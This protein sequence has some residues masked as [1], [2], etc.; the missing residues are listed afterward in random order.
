MLL[1]MLFPVLL[2]GQEQANNPA[3]I[4]GNEAAATKPQAT[5]ANNFLLTPEGIKASA[6]AEE[7]SKL[8]AAEQQPELSSADQEAGKVVQVVEPDKNVQSAKNKAKDRSL[9]RRSAKRGKRERGR[10]A[11]RKSPAQS[12]ETTKSG[13]VFDIAPIVVNSDTERL[14]DALAD[15][16]ATEIESITVLQESSKEQSKEQ[17]KPDIQ[18]E[19]I[20]QKIVLMPQIDELETPEQLVDSAPLVSGDRLLFTLRCSNQGATTADSLVITYPVPPSVVYSQDS[21]AGEA[22]TVLY[23]VDGGSSFAQLEYLQVEKK[24]R[25]RTP[26]SGDIT[27]VRWIHNVAFETGQGSVLTFEGFFK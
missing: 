17:L 24:G 1:V 11:N 10:K 8:P 12:V 3:V 14:L 21:A 15:E 7:G 9:R 18:V 6:Q 5:H 16:A 23:S 13:P 2:W 22:T 19:P 25:K 4:G 27:H 20:I 26:V